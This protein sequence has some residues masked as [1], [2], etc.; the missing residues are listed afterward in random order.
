VVIKLLPVIEVLIHLQPTLLVAEALELYTP[1]VIMGLLHDDWAG[2]QYPE[3]IE[4]D[5]LFGFIDDV[6]LYIAVLRYEY[7]GFQLFVAVAGFF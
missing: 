4:P 5:V 1:R 6:G 7:T 3:L 2:T